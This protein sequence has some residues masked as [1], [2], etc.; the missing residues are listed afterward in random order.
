MELIIKCN[1]NWGLNDGP[2]VLPVKGG[3]GSVLALE[4]IVKGQVL[5]ARKE[6][7]KVWS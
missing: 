2:G 1:L 7:H 3:Q 6:W 5:E 4:T